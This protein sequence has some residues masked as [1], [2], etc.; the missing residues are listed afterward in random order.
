MFL[1]RRYLLCLINSSHTPSNFVQLL[2]THWQSACDFLEVFGHFLK[3]LHVVELSNFYASRSKTWG[4]IDF[5]LPVI[6]SSA[7]N[8]NLGYNFWMIGTRALIF[9]MNVSC[10][11]TFPWV[12]KYLTLWPWCLTYLV[13]LMFDLL[14]ENFDLSYIF[15]MV[16]SRILIFDMSVPCDTTFP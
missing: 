3:N 7:E 14:N 6:L 10:N 9:H 12:L 11:K 13:T 4:H 15:W 2:S 5:V 1:N 8:F 16:R